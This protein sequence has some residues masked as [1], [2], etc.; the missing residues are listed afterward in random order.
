[1][2]WRAA[3]PA[4]SILR[5]QDLLERAV[6]SLKLE[7]APPTAPSA[8][9]VPVTAQLQATYHGD[10]RTLDV[11]GL[12]LATRAI[13]VNATGSLGSEKAQAHVSL[14]ATDLRELQPAIDALDPGTRIPIT[15]EGRSSFNGVIFGR[16]DALS[17]RGRLDLE[18][19]DTEFHLTGQPKG[20]TNQTSTYPLGRAFCRPVILALTAVSAARN[21]ATRRGTIRIFRQYNVTPGRL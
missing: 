2:N 5:G 4:T 15:L 17:T 18:K 16:L 6:S 13:R 10:A 21:T 3:F 14:N 8:K 20:R 12:T 1:M 11:A 19:F 7:V 9:E